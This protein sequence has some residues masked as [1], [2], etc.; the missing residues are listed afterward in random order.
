MS[1]RAPL[2]RMMFLVTFLIMVLIM[3]SS[4]LSRNSSFNR[5]D[6]IFKTTMILKDQNKAYSVSLHSITI[7]EHTISGYSDQFD[8]LMIFPLQYQNIK[9]VQSILDGLP[10]A[11]QEC[12][13]CHEKNGK[14]YVGIR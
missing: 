14:K 12:S 11:Y 2:L 13:L 5:N 10:Y 9:E 8:S 1:N 6:P 3:Y 4:Q 7:N